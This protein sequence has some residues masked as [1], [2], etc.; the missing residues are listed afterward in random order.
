MA[1]TTRWTRLER[2]L[3]LDHNP[4]RRRSD[5]IAGWLLPAVLAAL[6]VL[7]PLAA[8]VAGR[9]AQTNNAAAWRAQH[10][11]HHV[12]AV[13]L[14]STPGPMFPDG[15]ANSWTVWTPARWTFNGRPH[16]GKVP[17]ESG[18]RTGTTVTVWLDQAGNPRLPLSAAVAS[19]R[20]ITASALA[21]GALAL[22]LAS[23]AIIAHRVLSRRRF[24][25]WETAWMS[26]GPQWSE[27]T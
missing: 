13:L 21:V 16:V 17:A 12:P 2:H 1:S 3:G 27:R 14:A 15:G 6:L 11:W 19:D 8:I 18:S 22:L 5:L 23:M 7:G 10:S 25:S 26:V 20:V 4:L 9:W 24:A